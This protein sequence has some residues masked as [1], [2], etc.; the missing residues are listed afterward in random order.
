MYFDGIIDEVR[1]YNRALEASEV[2]E[3]YNASAAAYPSETTTCDLDATIHP[4][5]QDLCGDTIDNNCDGQVDY[6]AGSPVVL[7]CEFCDHYQLTIPYA[8]CKALE[9][10]YTDTDGASWTSSTGW[11]VSPDVDTWHGITAGT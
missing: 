11:M 7:E 2:V 8:E 4:G 6:K 3:L 1:I 10:L 9:A 5:Q